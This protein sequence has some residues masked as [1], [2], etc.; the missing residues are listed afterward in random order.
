MSGSPCKVL[1]LALGGTIACRN[2]KNG[3]VPELKAADLI[4]AAETP[5]GIQIDACDGPVRTI[6]FPEDWAFLAT[7]IFEG[8]E[9]YDGFVL[10]L[11]TDTL[12]YSSCA[13]SLMLPN[14]P[15]PVVLTGAMQPI[16]GPHPQP[17]QRNLADAIGIAASRVGGVF[18]VFH[19]KVLDGRRASK[20]SSDA[21]DAFASI[22]TPALASVG[23]G[24]IRWRDR[25]VQAS[26]DPRLETSIETRVAVLQIC[27]QTTSEDLVALERYSGIVIA[28]FGDGNVP[29]HLVPS[30]KALARRRVVVLASQCPKGRVWH[31]YAG[32]AALIRGG[33]ISSSDMTT[34]MAC[35]GLMWALGQSTSIT[36][37]R[38][39]FQT[40]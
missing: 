10:T 8:L 13:L 22:N 38:R 14:L 23:G 26:G 33:A 34:E 40:L 12:A 17:A 15:R 24:R 27:P 7:R 29:Q 2:S 11:G 25:P 21:D 16:T 9:E 5:S 35:V 1:L 19:G 30:L 37:V 39:I 36:T 32:G 6:L 31:R 20:T 28:G 4:A 3:L 18:V